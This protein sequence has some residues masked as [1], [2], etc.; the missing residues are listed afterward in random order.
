MTV[1]EMP[2]SD[3]Q[4]DA[5]LE[6]FDSEDETV[7]VD[8]LVKKLGSNP[9][10]YKAPERVVRDAITDGYLYVDSIDKKGNTFLGLTD[11]G[12]H[13][14]GQLEKAEDEDD[15]EDEDE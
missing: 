2:L 9:Y 3:A 5:I 11:A 8:Y 7:A 13:E 10:G 14:W 4:L 1:V 12:E 15:G 6:Q